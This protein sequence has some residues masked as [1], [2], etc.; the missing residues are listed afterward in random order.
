MPSEGDDQLAALFR[1]L[2]GSAAD[3]RLAGNRLLLVVFALDHLC[4]N[5]I[6]YYRL[7][8]VSAGACYVFTCSLRQSEWDLFDSSSE[9]D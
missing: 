4:S 2:P 3:P 1:G 9:E 6:D 5:P 7:R 8:M